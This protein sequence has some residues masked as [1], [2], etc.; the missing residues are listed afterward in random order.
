[1]DC[2]EEYI[3][4]KVIKY[5]Y[6]KEEHILAK[7]NNNMQKCTLSYFVN[8]MIKEGRFENQHETHDLSEFFPR[9]NR[10]TNKLGI[11]KNIK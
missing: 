11:E 4:S 8:I 1:M 5:A 6:R 2:L 9:K 7:T 10:Q 3:V